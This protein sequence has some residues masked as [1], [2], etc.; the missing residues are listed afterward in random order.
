MGYLLIQAWTAD[1]AVVVPVSEQRAPLP[2]TERF[3]APEITSEDAGDTDVPDS[4]LVSR[5]RSAAPTAAAL[6]TEQLIHI[7][8]PLQHVWIDPVG[9]DI[10]GLQLSLIHI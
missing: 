10:A 4:S 9:G 2:N 5:D 6:I 3:V 8:T 7:E 1:R